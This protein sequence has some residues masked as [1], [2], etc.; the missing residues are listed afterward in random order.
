MRMLLLSILFPWLLLILGTSGVQEPA[1]VTVKPSRQAHWRWKELQ[2]QHEQL[3]RPYLS[4]L[5]R[6]SMRAGVYRLPAGS[7]DTQSPHG[8]DELYYVVAGRSGF[9]A[10]GVTKSIGAGDVLYVEREVEHRFHD[11][12]EDLELLVFFST[13]QPEEQ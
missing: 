9:T 11:I 4:F 7:K 12:E 6:A 1:K 13:A 3:G 10:D 2:H 8:L 5:E